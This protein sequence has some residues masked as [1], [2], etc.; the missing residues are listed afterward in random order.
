MISISC[1]VHQVHSDI[2][3]IIKRKEE[4]F[5]CTEEE[6]AI[7]KQYLIDLS[8]NPEIKRIIIQNFP[9]EWAEVDP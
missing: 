6:S 7:I 1:Y 2:Y 9:I 4:G 8:I 3:S 5:D